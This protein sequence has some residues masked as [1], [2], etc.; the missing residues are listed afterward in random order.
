MYYDALS[1]NTVKI[2]L[3]EADMKEYL[4]KSENIGLKT[5]ETKRIFSRILERF[6][7]ENTMF[8]GYSTDRLFL[9][10]F[11]REGGGCVIYVSKLGRERA[12][13]ASKAT[14][15][16]V[17]M[18]TA[19]DINSVIKL[20]KGIEAMFPLSPSYL[21]HCNGSYRL[22]IISEKRYINR[23]FGIM[24]EYGEVSGDPIEICSVY[25]SGKVICSE[26][27]VAKLSVLA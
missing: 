14:E 6:R 9:E 27:A 13:S 19:G 25:E 4:L 12:E 22:I 11:A 20:S 21:Y 15:S 7:K 5:E 10:A 2:T 18:C 24:S 1:T 8:N 26:S 3:T 16:R 23:L 17:L